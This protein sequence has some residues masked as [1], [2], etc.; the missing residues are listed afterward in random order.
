MWNH[1]LFEPILRQQKLVLLCRALVT[2][3]FVE[4]CNNRFVKGCIL[5][6]LWSPWWLTENGYLQRMLIV[7]KMFN[8]SST[9][10]TQKIAW[11][12]VET[13]WSVRVFFCWMSQPMAFQGKIDYCYWGLWGQVHPPSFRFCHRCRFVR[14]LGRCFREF[15]LNLG[16]AISIIVRVFRVVFNWCGSLGMTGCLDCRKWFAFDF[17]NY[18]AIMLYNVWF[19]RKR[20]CIFEPDSLTV[21]QSDTTMCEEFGRN[22]YCRGTHYSPRRGDWSLGLSKCPATE[23]SPNW[24]DSSRI[25]RKKNRQGVMRTAFE[26]N[27]LRCGTIF[28][29]SVGSLQMRQLLFYVWKLQLFRFCWVLSLQTIPRPWNHFWYNGGAPCGFS[30]SS[31]YQVKILRSL[32]SWLEPSSLHLTRYLNAILAQLYVCLQFP[33]HV[34][35]TDWNPNKPPKPPFPFS[36]CFLAERLPTNSSYQLCLAST[37]SWIWWNDPHLKSHHTNLSF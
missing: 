14:M 27:M 25:K 8:S 17:G 37:S 35:C 7:S 34:L 28:V 26:K 19:A 20:L 3:Q 15:G 9:C 10:F 2:W 29:D 33:V 12:G 21:N 32:Q 30:K 16:T 4:I 13:R 23:G 22:G 11:K 24:F 36:N 5:G 1:I 31:L 6:N 18:D